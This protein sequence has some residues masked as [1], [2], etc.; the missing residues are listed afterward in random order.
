MEIN[1]RELLEILKSVRVGIVKKS[2]LEQAGHFVFTGK[3]VASYNDQIC[4]SHPFKTDFKCSLPAEE[5]EKILGKIKEDLIQFSFADDRLLIKSKKTKASLVASIDEEI[6][7]CINK[8]KLSKIK[9][10]LQPIPKGFIEGLRMC[11][12]SVSS[13]MTQTHLTCVNI[14]NN[15]IM[16]SDD[17]RVS[18]YSLPEPID[19]K[20]LIPGTSVFEL[21]EFPIETYHFERNWAYFATENGCFFCCRLVDA[22][23]DDVAELYDAFDN[24]PYEIIKFPEDTQKLVE[25]VSILADGEFEMDK[26]ITISVSKGYMTFKGKNVKGWIEQKLKIKYKGEDLKMCINPIFLSQILDKTA[27][28]KVNVKLEQVMFTTKHFNHLVSLNVAD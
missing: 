20:L 21:V 12:F 27:K 3:E 25:N 28:T 1:R 4:I 24:E 26:R 23:F 17:F 11:M 7:E 5:L 8:L 10:K 19:A 13:D 9:K 2:E 22:Q 18:M 14:A 15:R 16:S 6:Y